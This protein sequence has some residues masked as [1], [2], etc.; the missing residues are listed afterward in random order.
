M[1]NLLDPKIHSTNI[2]TAQ[3]WNIVHG[4]LLILNVWSRYPVWEL[5]KFEDPCLFLK[6]NLSL[7]GMPTTGYRIRIEMIRRSAETW[8][9]SET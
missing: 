7:Q 5:L 1:E 6:F 8:Y 9:R 2:L 3:V 4:V